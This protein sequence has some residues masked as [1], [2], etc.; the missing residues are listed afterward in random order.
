MV[1]GFIGLIDVIGFDV[2]QPIW[3]WGCLTYAP[4][5]TKYAFFVVFACFGAYVGQPHGHIGWAKSIS[6]ASF[7]PI[8]P[9]IN[10]WNFHKK[11]LT[12]G[13]FEK[14]PVFESAILNFLK[15]KKKKIEKKK[16][17]QN[18][19]LKKQSFS[20]P[21]S[22]IFFAT[23]SRIGSWVSIDAK[24]ID[25]AQSIWPSGCPTFFWVGHFWF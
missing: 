19:R 1:L 6:F 4:K 15:I 16:K 7:N 21:Q 2:A 22:S 23:I 25:V 17:I 14:W 24:G 5:Q 10:P 11:I 18:G 9:R 3:P 8:N 20:Q 12:I 13:D